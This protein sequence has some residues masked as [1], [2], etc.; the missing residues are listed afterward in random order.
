MGHVV[1]PSARSRSRYAVD[2]L[3]PEECRRTD[4]RLA[5]LTDHALIEA[6]ELLDRLAEVALADWFRRQAARG[7]KVPS[8]I[9][10][11]L[12]EPPL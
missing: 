12:D 2:M 1:E 3:S 7:S 9:L 4:P 10:P 11:F 5:S 6:A 8:G